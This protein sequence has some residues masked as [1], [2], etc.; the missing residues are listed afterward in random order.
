MDQD[1]GHGAETSARA[2]WELY[3]LPPAEFV[4]ARTT[5]VKRLR[6][7]GLREEATSVAALRRPS[8][9]AAAMNGLVRAE[10]PVAEWLQD[11][12]TRL[13]HA[14]SALDA[15]GLRAMRGE[16]DQLLDD[17]VAAAQEHADARL[18]S[19]VEA[20][21]RSTA[22]AALAE[23]E[24]AEVVL[25][26]TLTRALSYSGF[27]EVDVSDAV[28]RTST[29]V[30]L[31]RIEGGGSGTDGAREP[32]GDPEAN[33]DPAADGAKEEVAEAS[34]DGPAHE[35]TDGPAHEDTAPDVAVAAVGA[36]SQARATAQAQA[37]AAAAELAQ[38]RGELE[39][40]ETEVGSARGERRAAA[41]QLE[42][43]ASRAAVADRGLEQARRLLEQAET[44]AARALAEQQEA[45][46]GLEAAEATLDLARE[47]RDRARAALEEAEDAS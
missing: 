7:D 2:A 21:V 14:Q 25:S 39:E 41:E 1:G 42:A 33:G 24:A 3:G 11:V 44:H 17:W 28:A 37:E 27:G 20:E 40:A 46:A 32:A 13:R 31:T 12:G 23:A 6:S 16:R 9:A 26:G 29:G 35:D 38:L 10:H 4:A 18:T 34:D 5:W 8:V 15:A 22:V 30:V 45:Q 36:E 43:A 47:R 19:A